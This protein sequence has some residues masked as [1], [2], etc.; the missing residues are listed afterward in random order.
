MCKLMWLLLVQ[1]LTNWATFCSNIWSHR[2]PIVD[3]K[4]IYKT[5]PRLPILF[6]PHRPKLLVS[7]LLLLLCEAKKW[8]KIITANAY[9]WATFSANFGNMIWHF[10]KTFQNLRR[11]WRLSKS[12]HRDPLNQSI[13]IHLIKIQRSTSSKHR[14]PLNQSIEIHLIKAQRST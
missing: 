3:I 13:E 5:S 7:E 12:K 14:D 1:M 6:H 8:E 10:S 2:T 9:F 11:T 4:T